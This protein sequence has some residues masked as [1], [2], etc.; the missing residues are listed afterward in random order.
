MVYKERKYL[1]EY[2]NSLEDKYDVNA[3]QIDN[4]A[5]WPAIKM[6]LFWFLQTPNQDEADIEQKITKTSK[7]VLLRRGLSAF[8]KINFLKKNSVVFLFN[9][10]H[11]TQDLGKIENKYFVSI[12][13][14]L[15]Q[16]KKTLFYLDYGSV[17]KYGIQNNHIRLHEYFVLKEK[18]K[19]TQL[20]QYRLDASFDTLCQQIAADFRSDKDAIYASIIFA[21]KQIVFYKK[22]FTKLYTKT[23]PIAI[24][25]LCYYSLQVYGANLAAKQLKIKTV[26]MQHGGQGRYHIA[27][28]GYSKIPQ[29][30]YN[31]LPDVFW[32]WNTLSALQLTNMVK[33]S[34]HQVVKG[35]NPWINAKKAYAPMHIETNKRAYILI[36][37]QPNYDLPNYLL[38]AIKETEDIY[39]WG[40]R[41]H[42]RQ[43]VREK[44]N[45]LSTIEVNCPPNA[46]DVKWANELSISDLLKQSALHISRYSGS[47]EEAA[48]LGVF[49]IIIDP[50]GIDMYDSLIA[51]GYA[52][53]YIGEETKD[54][55]PLLKESTKQKISQSKNKLSLEDS[56]CQLN[57]Y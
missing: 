15:K 55:M 4:D 17:E 56:L 6:Q 54:F 48:D 21:I 42:P 1:V 39:L 14:I 27:Y 29:K 33:A 2:L 25:E 16:K 10:E 49:S 31:L 9:Q 35:G 38:K 3:W 57:I 30:G 43:T 13:K 18:L 8:I 50:I 7:F 44:G 19:K 36:T 32:V 51:E 26:E 11:L 34:R 41:F 12:A 5:M 22:M 47:I 45:I 23:K 53:E 20:G 24:F 52:E 40:I 28:S 46:F 37:L